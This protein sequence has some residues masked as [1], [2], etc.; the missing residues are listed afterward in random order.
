M[1]SAL[2]GQGYAATILVVD[3]A[4]FPD[5]S[6]AIRL[7]Q[8]LR[9]EVPDLVIVAA[10]ERFQEHDMSC[11]QFL[12]ADASV[13]LPVSPTALAV[14]ISAAMTNHAFTRSLRQNVPA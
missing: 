7:L 13:R 1:R 14:A 5:L 6:T 11:D 4:V 9:T 3:L 10:S 12:M 8:T 2:R